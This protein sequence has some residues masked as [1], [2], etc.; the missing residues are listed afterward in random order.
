MTLAALFQRQPLPNS[1]IAAI[2][3]MVSIGVVGLAVAGTAQMCHGPAI[4]EIRAP[5]TVPA[6]K[7]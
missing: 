2:L 6:L 5:M 4:D 3:L 1:A 7:E